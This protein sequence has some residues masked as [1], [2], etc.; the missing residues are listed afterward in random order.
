[1]SIRTTLGSIESVAIP[2]LGIDSVIAK[3]DTGAWSGTLHCT[4]IEEKDGVLNFTP[5]GIQSL[6]TSTR[7]F[8]TR[9]VRSAHGDVIRRY[10]VPMQIILRGKKYDT[11][12]GLSDRELMRREMLLGRK[13]LLENNI[14]VDVTLT[15]EDDHEAEAGL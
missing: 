7:D 3:V 5:M 9:L 12:V 10:I 8:D 11:V 15:V 6:R 4:D 2:A 1:M 13:F 14:L